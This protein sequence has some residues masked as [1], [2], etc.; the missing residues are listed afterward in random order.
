M[1]E[2]NPAMS[3][4]SVASGADVACA[5]GEAAANSASNA[6]SSLASTAGSNAVTEAA[7]SATSQASGSKQSRTYVLVHGAWHGAWCWEPVA[8]ILRSQG[9]QV[10]TPTL[11]GVGERAHLISPEIDLSVFIQDVV[12]VFEQ[13]DLFEVI[14]VGHSF[15]GVT[16]V[17]AAERVPQ[18]IRQLVFLDAV[19]LSNGETAFSRLAPEIVAARRQQALETSG[20]LTIPVPPPNAFGVFEPD[21][22][23]LLARHCTPHP[24]KTFD[25]PIKLSG[26]P[27]GALPKVYIQCVDPVYGPLQTSRDFV[28]TQ[29]G[30]GWDEIATGHDAMVSASAALADKLLAFA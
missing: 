2:G 14:L 28:K 30:W 19:V 4:E 9:H 27:G 13:H 21:Q 11:S 29:A 12:D 22:V 1:S 5:T 8:Q 20:G 26:P 16:L 18:R 15:G 6:A 10:F 23:A 7:T 24:L 3:H 17:G 25:D